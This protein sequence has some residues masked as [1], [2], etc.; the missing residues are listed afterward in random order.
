MTTDD[1]EGMFKWEGALVADGEVGGGE[2]ER[3]LSHVGLSGGSFPF[4]G[5]RG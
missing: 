3:H 1:D 5:E 2:M 4:Q